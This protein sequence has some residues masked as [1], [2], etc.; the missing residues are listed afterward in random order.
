MSGLQSGDGLEGPDQ[1]RGTSEESAQEAWWEMGDLNK[2][3]SSGD[4][5]ARRG[6][7]EG[8]SM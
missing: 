7:V 8:D 4:G 6:L 3:V 1:G 2:G 5:E